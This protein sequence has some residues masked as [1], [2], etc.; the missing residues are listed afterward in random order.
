MIEPK[1]PKSHG[2]ELVLAALGGL[3]EIGMNAY[4]YGLGPA[5]DRKWL[6]IDLGITFPHEAEPGVD[7]VL[8]DPKF[9]EG[10]R[11]SLVGLVLTHAH[12]DHI[13]AVLDLWPRLKCPI[14]ATPFTAGMLQAKNV[15]NG[16][17]VK[18]PITIVRLGSRFKV[19]PF[20]LELVTLAHSIPE[21]SGIA[22]RTPHGLVFHTGDWKLDAT[23]LIGD[24]SNDAKL[25]ALGE[26][27]VTAIVCDSTNAM[28]EGHSPSEIEV[29]RSIADIIAGAKRRVAV[30]TFASNVARVRAVADAALAAGRKLVVSGRAM[31]RVIRVAKDTGY[32][33]ESFSALDQEHFAYLEP[34]EAVLLCTGSQGEARAA[35]AR[36][37]DDDHPVIELG[38]GDLVIFSSRPIP[39][40]EKA[41][42]KVQ[43]GLARMGCDI[44]TDAEKLVH[45]TGHPRRDELRQIYR[46]LKP[47]IAIPM[48]GE[49]RHLA[50]HAKLARE[51]GVVNVHAITDG[52]VFKIAPGPS[53]IIDEIPVG[54]LFRDG[55]LIVPG[56]DGPVRERRKLGFVGLVAV[57]LA[58]DERGDLAGDPEVEIDGVPTKTADGREMVDVILTTVE[59][60][61][62]SIPPKRRKDEERVREAVRRAVRASVDQV[63]GKKPIVK[64]LIC[65]V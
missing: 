47:K 38:R 2:S 21:P 50:E 49:A 46:W 54:R 63:W 5:D 27:G 61:I 29:A 26:E 57:A 15:E 25:K 20:D 62:E 7:V 6:M 39:G 51:E 8:P 12:E 42:A 3:G 58:L 52:D 36:I 30:T 45:V 31:H 14:Y 55:K 56:E 65:L 22:I 23:P 10:E 64:V 48:H 32:L 59:G 28:R 16:S 37:A 24:P 41:I 13:G 19:G 34:H 35:M 40:N 53:M 4:L 11:K 60:T 9:I 18:L 44:V 33:P 17:R 43:N 1:D